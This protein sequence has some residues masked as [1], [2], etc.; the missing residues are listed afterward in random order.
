MLAGVL[1]GDLSAH[2]SRAEFDCH[3]GQHG[4]PSRALI[5]ALERL[6]AICG[7]HPLRIISGYRDRAYNARIGGA[8]ESQ[9]IYNRAADIPTGYATIEQA[10][11]AGFTGIGYAGRWV[12]HVDVRP[13]AVVVFADD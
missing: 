10:R 6:R 8:K 4:N 9:H 2:F 5:D 11:Q 7:G 1:M 13:G 12:V 3:D